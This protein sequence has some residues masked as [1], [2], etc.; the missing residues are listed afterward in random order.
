MHCVVDT[1]QSSLPLHIEFA[2]VRQRHGLLDAIEAGLS[3]WLLEDALHRLDAIDTELRHL[4]GR[5]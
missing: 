4:W 5:T 1:H 3:G 2:L